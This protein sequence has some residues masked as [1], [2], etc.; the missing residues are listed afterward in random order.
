MVSQDGGSGLR[1]ERLSWIARFL[2][3]LSTQL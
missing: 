3:V 1:F 2:W